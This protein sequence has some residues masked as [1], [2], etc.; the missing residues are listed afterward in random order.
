M[1]P[2]TN[3]IIAYTN[4]V[5]LINTIKN[6]EV[7]ITLADKIT[8]VDIS[9]IKEETNAAIKKEEKFESFVNDYVKDKKKTEKFL[10]QLETTNIDTLLIKI[11]NHINKEE[12]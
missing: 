6:E 9:K 5:S 11:M 1:K 7:R 8:K 3:K 12:I 4:L 10:N 2:L